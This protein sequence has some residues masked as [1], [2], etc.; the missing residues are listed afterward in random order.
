MNHFRI[1]RAILAVAVASAAAC[2]SSSSSSPATPAATFGVTRG[3]ITAT[4]PAAHT[5]TVNG[6]TISVASAT[7]KSEK[8]Q[9]TEAELHHGMIVKVTGS[10]DDRTG[11][12]TQ[13]E[14]EDHVKGR[15]DSDPASTP[16]SINV[17]GKTVHVDDTAHLVDDTTGNDITHA[18]LHPNDRLRISGYTD[19]LGR[20][21]A[22]SVERQAAAS[23]DDSFEMKGFVSGLSSSGG[24]T[25]F[26]LSPTLPAGA[27]S[28]TVH[29]PDAGVAA[30]IASNS[31]VEVHAA[32][33]AAAGVVTATTVSLE[34]DHLAENEGA[35]VEVEGIVISGTSASFTVGNQ[36]VTTSASTRWEF[37]TAGDLAAGSK[38][39]VDGHLASGVL[40]AGKVSF[41][42]NVRIQ[43]PITATTGTPVTSLTILGFTVSVS[44][45]TRV[46]DLPVAG[47]T[48]FEIRGVPQRNAG[49]AV[50]GILATRIRVRNGG[51]SNNLF[52]QGP[53]DQVSGNTLQI[54]GI[55]VDTA[56]A[57]TLNHRQDSDPADIPMSR[58]AFLAALTPGRSVVKA[59]LS[60]AP[61][62]GAATATEVELEDEPGVHK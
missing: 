58:T 36:A 4:N 52:V 56:G 42:A 27:E 51:G 55:A 41:R 37:G 12:A 16:A 11:T 28:F 19:D 23:G 29:V 24:T 30:G 33:A 32:A 54:L 21:H 5:I 25:T 61:A 26:T 20:F 44:D 53:V 50:T 48:V 13:V 9:K 39:E 40:V 46:E 10:V 43:A 60:A 8:V 18:D 49:G 3:A 35:E 57:T 31:F 6:A 15:V 2:G 47:A 22:S 45:L 38:V 7:I 62:S 14:F 17:G 1:S 34:N 59:K